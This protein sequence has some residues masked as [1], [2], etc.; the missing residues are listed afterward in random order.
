[1]GESGLFVR[2][3]PDGYYKLFIALD[4]TCYDAG[5]LKIR[6]KEKGPGKTGAL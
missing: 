5:V 2:E 6:I 3:V 1:L 4:L